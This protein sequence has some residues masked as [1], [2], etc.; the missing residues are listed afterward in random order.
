MRRETIIAFGAKPPACVVAV[1][2]CCGAHHMGRDLLAQGYTVQL[3]SP[4][5]TRPYV[6]AH[7]ND[8]RDAEAIAEADRR[9]TMW[10]V[11]LKL[12]AQLDV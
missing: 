12:K 3:M 11:T 7:K 1:E 6:K 9:P 10:F 8:D 4:E 2:A 5:Y